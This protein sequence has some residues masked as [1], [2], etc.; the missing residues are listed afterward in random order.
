[1]LKRTAEEFTLKHCEE[2]LRSAPYGCARLYA[3]A[4]GVLV[5]KHSVRKRKKRSV[6]VQNGTKRPDDGE[7]G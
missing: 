2:I 7:G 3:I 4:T 6:P 1:L 5:S